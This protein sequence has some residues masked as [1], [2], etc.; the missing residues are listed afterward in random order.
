[1]TDSGKFSSA[2][3][4]VGFIESLRATYP[5]Y[6]VRLAGGTLVLA[7]MFLMAYNVWRTVSGATSNQKVPVMQPVAAS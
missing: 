6:G 3:L 2:A 1:M 5:Y 4:S 7:G